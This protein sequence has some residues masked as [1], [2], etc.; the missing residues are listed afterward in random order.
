VV[1]S[2]ENTGEESVIEWSRWRDSEKVGR[3]MW[4]GRHKFG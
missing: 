1:T 2:D 3:Y 4:V